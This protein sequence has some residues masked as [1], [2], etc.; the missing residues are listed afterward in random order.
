MG[1]WWESLRKGRVHSHTPRG[2]EQ[3]PGD[4]PRGG[5]AAA[6]QVA[7]GGRAPLQVDAKPASAAT[8]G[9]RTPLPTCA[10]A[11]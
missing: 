6:P 8:R 3:I 4:R 9:T 2:P 10:R 7:G 11:E 1:G 5:G